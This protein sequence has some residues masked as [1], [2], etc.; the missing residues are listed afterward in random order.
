M[1]SDTRY[2][3]S[4]VV[5]DT[6]MYFKAYMHGLTAKREEALPYSPKA[7]DIC[8]HRYSKLAENKAVRQTHWLQDVTLTQVV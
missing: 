1:K 8:C 3:I 7:I 4:I 6:R 5:N 2:I